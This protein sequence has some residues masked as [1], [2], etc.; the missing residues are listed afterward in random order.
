[1]RVKVCGIK[2]VKDALKAVELGV[3]AVGLLVG[4]KHSANDFIDMGQAR[5]ITHHLP[6]FCSSV[7]V[8]HIEGCNDI[9]ALAKFIGVTTIQLHNNSSPD[10]ALHI[11]HKLPHIKLIKSLHVVDRTSIEKGRKFLRSVDAILLD[12]INLATDQVGGT[13]LTHDWNLSREIVSAYDIP[14][15]LAGGL[16]PDNV[17]LA[18]EKV[19]PFGVDANSGTKGENG[20]KDYKKLEAFIRNAKS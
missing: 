10:D 5:V 13:G 1:M 14:V 12:T 3:D 4:Q 8:T 9:V 16:D 6:P 2:N 18:I 20:F 19:M 11:K 7:L 17:A 15:I